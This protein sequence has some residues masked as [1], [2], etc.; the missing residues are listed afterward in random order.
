MRGFL[1]FLHRLLKLRGAFG[2]R[3]G[4]VPMLLSST[5][6]FHP[7]PLA[8]GLAGAG[9]HGLRGNDPFFDFR[10]QVDIRDGADRFALTEE[11]LP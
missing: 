6:L 11:T 1:A 3:M 10:N 5:D 4:E 7:N 8:M 2:F 9:D